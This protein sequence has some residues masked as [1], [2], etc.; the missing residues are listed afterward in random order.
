MPNVL[1]S[2]RCVFDLAGKRRQIA[3]LE[4]RAATPTFW[5]DPRDAQRVLQS[6]TA[7]REQTERWLTLDQ[8]IAELRELAELADGDLDLLTEVEAQASSLTL[9]LGKMEFDLLLNGKYD[10]NHAMVEVTPGAGGVEAQDWAQMLVRMYLRWAQQRNFE[11]EMLDEQPGEEAGIKSATFMIRGR[12]AYGYLSAERG[13]HRLV[14]LSPF[15]SA[16]RRHTSFALVQVMP[17]VEQDVEVH[18]DPNDLRVDT[19]RSTGAGGQHINKTDSAVRITHLPTGIVVTCQNERSQIQNREVAMNILRARL[20]E[21]RLEEQAAEQA[22]L[23]GEVQSAEFGSQIRNYV[24]H[25]YNLVK[26]LRSGVETSNVLAVLD[27]D[28]DAFLEAYLRWK[29]GPASVSSG[30]TR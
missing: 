12:Y 30:N 20:L 29:V 3:E 16:H 17:E 18:I 9:R 6:L 14:R 10:A 4:Q 5:D 1:K 27:G 24:L 19:Y 13:T 22:H 7:L 26:D 2:F 21:R 25:P 15:D 23:R 8:E 11:A 28:L